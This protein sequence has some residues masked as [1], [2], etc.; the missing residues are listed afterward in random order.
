M[1]GFKV[2]R[3]NRLASKKTRST[4]DLALSQNWLLT[5]TGGGDVEQWLTG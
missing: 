4:Y 1:A 5:K 3:L 2:K